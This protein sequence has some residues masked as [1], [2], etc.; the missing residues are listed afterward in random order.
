MVEALHRGMDHNTEV[1]ILGLQNRNCM[2]LGVR[3][4]NQEGEGE[5]DLG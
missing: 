4:G 2:G 5:M 1:F 3:V